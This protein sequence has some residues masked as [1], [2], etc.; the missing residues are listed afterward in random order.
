MFKLDN[1]IIFCIFREIGQ[2]A[3]EE[4]RTRDLKRDLEDRERN[5]KDKSDRKDRE[6]ARA[7]KAA[8]LA[9]PSVQ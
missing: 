9:G 8:L 7:S 5:L 2:G 3:A 1:Q 6:R 4:I